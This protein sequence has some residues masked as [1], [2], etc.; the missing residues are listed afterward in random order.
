[1]T[2]KKQPRTI[3][4]GTRK[5]KLAMAQTMMVAEALK[6]AEPG[7]Q[8]EI[9]PVVTTGDKILDRALTE[10]GGKGVF[11]SEFE[12]GILAGRFDAA[13]HS[14]KDMPMELLDGLRVA[15]V[16]PRTDAEDVFVTVKGREITNHP[17]VIGTGSLRRQLQI[18][19][20]KD[21]VCKLIRGNVD[22]RLAKL[23]DGQY[24]AII[25]AAAGL[26]RLGL[27]E[28]ERFEFEYLPTDSFT[29]A[30]GQAIIAIEAKID[31]EFAELFA[32]IN[33]E[34]SDLALQTE[35]YTLEC[36]GAGCNEAVGVYSCLKEE[37]LVIQLLKETK[38]GLVRREVKGAPSEYKALVHELIRSIN[39]GF[40]YLVGAGPGDPEL[41]TL[42]GKR[43]LSQAEVLVYD[44][45]ASPE[46]LNMVPDTCEKIYVGKVP[47]NHSM[48]QDEINQVLVHYGLK[49]KKIVRLK[50]GDP[51]VFGRGGEEIL[52]LEKYGIPY[53]VVSGVTSPVAAL[54]HAGIPIT[55][56]GIGQSFHVITGHT[57]IKSKGIGVLDAEEDTLTDGFAEYAKLQGTLVFLMGLKNLDL[58]VDRL[59]KNGKDPKTQAAIVTDGTLP[60]MRCV[61][62]TLQ[63]LPQLAKEYGLK[64]PGIIVVGPV[65]GFEMTAKKTLALS[66]LSVGVTGTDAIYEKLASKLYA[67]GASVSRIGK[68]MILPLNED[69]LEQTVRSIQS[70][71]WIVFTSRNAIDLFFRAVRNENI[72]MRAFCHVKFAVVGRG[73]KEYLE[74]FGFY[75]D[76][77]PDEF[78]TES[79]A[80]GLSLVVKAREHVLIPRAKQGSQRLTEIL[81]EANIEYTDLSIYDVKAEQSKVSDLNGLDFLTFESGSGVRGFFETDPEEKIKIL[82][83]SV[84]PVCIGHVTSEVLK[85]YGV[86]RALVAKDYTAD[87]ICEILKEGGHDVSKNSGRQ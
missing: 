8:V 51:F 52:E 50:G 6:E 60:S 78:T 16:L 85:E 18:L 30:G 5:S 42:K 38:Q 77:M 53:E 55:H 45:L 64:S 59:I 43:L 84:Y 79:L 4:L 49:G 58:I 63:T 57:A 75:A 28:D 15:A 23:Y 81:Q 25:L 71:Q 3:R 62:G 17:M 48:V 73:T 87:G 44:R 41:L 83:H 69:V 31:S 67:E 34:P 21:A 40:V 11:I 80:K 20:Q 24:D 37:Q 65:A 72:D 32:K 10:F 36:L 13:V 39:H 2:E 46:F 74:Q 68:S 35:R 61:R 66:G 27:F 86:T 9:V 26:K 1:M 12:E 82:N 33:H 56:R 22:T 14:A 7:I 29:P 47:G 70:Y 19:E 76:Y 54:A